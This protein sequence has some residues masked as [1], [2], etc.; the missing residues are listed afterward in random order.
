[1]EPFLAAAINRER[2]FTL[3]PM[4]RLRLDQSYLY[5]DLVTREGDAPSGVPAGERIV[6]NHILRTRANYQFTREL[7][8][9]AILDYEAVSPNQA[10]VRLD[11]EKRV[12]LDLLATYLVNPWTAVYV[13]YTDAY[14]NW[15]PGWVGGRPVERGGAPTDSVGRAVLGQL[16]YLFAY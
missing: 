5:V 4:S 8:L 10:L 6:T 16:S 9:R 11:P 1:M 15:R 7:S 3:K 2:G 13:G 12:S 14:E